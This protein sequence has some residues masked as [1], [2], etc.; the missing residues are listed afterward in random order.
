M[1]GGREQEAESETEC[2]TSESSSELPVVTRL[3][4]GGKL[5]RWNRL[6]GSGHFGNEF[7]PTASSL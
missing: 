7:L 1:G 4:K 5:S 2:T 6:L 3:Q